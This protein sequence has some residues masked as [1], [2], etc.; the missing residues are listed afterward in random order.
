[1]GGC[2]HSLEEWIEKTF[3]LLI[4]GIM[5][6]LIMLYGPNIALKYKEMLGVSSFTPPPLS[7]AVTC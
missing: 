7:G 5:G 6:S 4:L 3:F 2:G 1:M